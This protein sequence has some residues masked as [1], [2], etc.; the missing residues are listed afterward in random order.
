MVRD[1][2]GAAPPPGTRVQLFDLPVLA[3]NVGGDGSF[4]L[5]GIPAGGTHFVYA[6][7]PQKT[8]SDLAAVAFGSDPVRNFTLN[9]KPF[10]GGGNPTAFS[11]RVVSSSGSA[12]GGATVWRLGAAGRTSSASTGSFM[13]IDATHES[14]DPNSSLGRAPDAVTLVAIKDDRWGF[15]NVD[16]NNPPKPMAIALDHQG[17]APQPPKIF[18]WKSNFAA[19]QGQFFTARWK[20]GQHKDLGIR[21]VLSNKTVSNPGGNGV[22]QCV[23]DCSGVVDAG[24]VV[25]LPAGQSFTIVAWN[26]AVGS[27]GAAEPNPDWDEAEV[28]SR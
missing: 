13:L 15:L 21:L 2:Q 12:V 8:P 22:G 6:T 16:S 19:N 5:S 28:V 14:P 20:N 23:G 11:G 3:A 7:A 25:A 1:D 4:T 18:D 17:N 26:E 24:L 27:D 9:L 10:A